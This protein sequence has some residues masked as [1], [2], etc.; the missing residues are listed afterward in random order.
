MVN[1]MLI[2]V[3]VFT[4]LRFSIANRYLAVACTKFAVDEK[5]ERGGQS[6]G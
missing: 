5:R 4:S 2:L 1:F 3:A 6:I